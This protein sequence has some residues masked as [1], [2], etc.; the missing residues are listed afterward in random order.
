MIQSF[1]GDEFYKCLRSCLTSVEGQW[2]GKAFYATL[3]RKDF[4]IKHSVIFDQR[5]RHWANFQNVSIANAQA[6]DT[7]FETISRPVSTQQDHIE[8][9]NDINSG[10]QKHS[11]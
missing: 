10:E 1:S 7:F 6:L 9:A 11:S 4:E 8:N 3:D 5:A 2:D